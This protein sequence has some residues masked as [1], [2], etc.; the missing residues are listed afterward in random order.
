MANSKFTAYLPPG[1]GNHQP[2]RI[3]EFVAA[4]LVCIIIV[5]GS[6]FLAGPLVLITYF[7]C[8]GWI[9]RFMSHRVSWWNQADN[10]ENVYRAKVE[11]FLK[12]PVTVPKFIW[13]V[14]IA[15]VL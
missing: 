15:K 13:K 10:I 6:F 8:G 4:Y 7:V 5:I 1:P 2:Y 3:R 12:W 9:G 14:A 11:T